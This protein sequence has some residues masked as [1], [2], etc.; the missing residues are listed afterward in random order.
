MRLYYVGGCRDANRLLKEQ[1][2]AD[3]REKTIAATREMAS[4][5]DTLKSALEA[6]DVDAVG[7]LLHDAWKQ[8]RSLSDSVT[9]GEIDDVYERARAAG[10]TGG[11]LLGAGAGGFILL[12][13]P[14]HD[15]LAAAL[16]G[17]RSLPFEVDMAGSEII[18]PK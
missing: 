6:G 8:K 11:K 14:N 13:H 18:F 15:R 4:N 5:V 3:R 17:I 10:S 2:A 16:Q 9:N 1:G 12:A 7:P